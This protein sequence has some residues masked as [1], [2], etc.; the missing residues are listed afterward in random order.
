MHDSSSH[1]RFARSTTV[2]YVGVIAC[3]LA[4]CGSPTA[5][6]F[7]T[8][9]APLAVVV[10]VRDSIS[11]AAAAMNALGTIVGEGVDDTLRQSD[12]LTLLGGDRLG[13][14]TVKIEK[15]GYFTWSQSDVRVTKTGPCGNVLPV[16]LTARLQPQ[17]P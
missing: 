10:T 14:F 8:A 12:S 1:K 15:S 17:T 3:A 11:G 5:V 16:S 6:G 13:T 2:A 9:P 4:A 7:C